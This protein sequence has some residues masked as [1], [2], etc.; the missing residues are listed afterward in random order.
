MM[1]VV[2]MFLPAAMSSTGS[3]SRNLRS[4]K[5]SGG[6]AAAAAVAVAAAGSGD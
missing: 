4:S 5:S 1:L 6:A 3:P 2:T